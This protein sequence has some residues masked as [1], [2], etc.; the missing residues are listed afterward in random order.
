MSVPP[1]RSGFARFLLGP[2]LWWQEAIVLVLVDL[3]YSSLRGRVVGSEADALRNAYRL[4]DLERALGIFHEATVQGWM[5]PYRT[6]IQ[7]WDIY[8]GTIHFVVPVVVLVILWRRNRDRYRL[9]RNA[10]G[11][12]LAL[13]L[14]G[15]A[16]WPLAPPRLMPAPY[17]LVDTDATIGGLGP[18]SRQPGTK[19]DDNPYAAMPSLHVG[20]STWC[21]LAAYPVLRRRWSRALIVVYPFLTLIAIVVTA[22]H[23]FLDAVGGW[24]ALAG[25]VAMA[26]AL[27]T[28]AGRRRPNV[29]VH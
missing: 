25:G 11:F 15:F 14:V 4:I 13:G 20:W 26:T 16:L 19:G 22:N 3:I 23:Y 1:S 7:F 2:R 24:V 8:Y 12:M 21:T 28:I 27:S 9:W 5:L 17:A 10:F 29:A 18:M 6:V